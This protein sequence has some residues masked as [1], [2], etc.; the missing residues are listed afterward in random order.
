MT[1]QVTALAVAR[2]RQR[3]GLTNVDWLVIRTDVEDALRAGRGGKLHPNGSGYPCEG[4]GIYVWTPNRERIY[5]IEAIRSRSRTFLRVV[6]S[7]PG[8]YGS[9]HIRKAA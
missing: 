2:A 8:C 7:L 6:T 5:V 3:Y 4:A 1:I 9:A